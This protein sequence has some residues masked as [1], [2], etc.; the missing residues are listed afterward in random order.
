MI[1]RLGLYL[2]LLFCFST[3]SAASRS[4]ILAANSLPSS[5]FASIAVAVVENAALLCFV[6]TA[7]PH[8]FV[9]VTVA[10]RVG[11]R[12]WLAACLG[13]RLEVGAGRI[14][15][16][17]AASHPAP[18]RP[19]AASGAMN[20]CAG[21]VWWCL[22]CRPAASDAGVARLNAGLD[23]P[24]RARGPMRR[25]PEAARPE[26][27]PSVVLRSRHDGDM[28]L[29]MPPPTSPHGS[30]IGSRSLSL[31][32]VEAWRVAS[33][34]VEVCFGWSSIDSPPEPDA[35]DLVDDICED[36]VRSRKQRAEQR[37]DSMLHQDV[38]YSRLSPNQSHNSQPFKNTCSQAD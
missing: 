4:R 26:R 36:E 12:K 15:N 28:V 2:G 18:P 25:L 38:N 7:A 31:S 20:C 8:R 32:G 27:P 6:P 10:A 9:L 35:S 1:F 16:G 34:R 14:D 24:R 23:P 13:L 21:A 22:C 17:G 11:A 37:R 29:Q 30:P 33:F 3:I 5:F 19:L